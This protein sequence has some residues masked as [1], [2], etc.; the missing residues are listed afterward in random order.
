MGAGTIASAIG[1]GQEAR[2]S[3]RAAKNNARE[4]ELNARLAIERAQEDERQFRLSFRRD[5]GRNI[6]AVGASGIKLEGSPIE[7]LRDNAANAERDA[8]NIRRAG[9]LE[10]SSY[11]RQAK[12][13]KRAAKDARKAGD[14]AI[15]STLLSGAG[16]IYGSR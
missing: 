10:R 7:V 15:A 8:Q 6:T 9:E 4:A 14:L 2:A 12:N 5:E 13:F 3:A 1:A 16:Q 11:L